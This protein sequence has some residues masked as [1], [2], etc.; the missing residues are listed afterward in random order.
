MEVLVHS[1]GLP[2][3]YI[4]VMPSR[5]ASCVLHKAFGIVVL[6]KPCL[7]ASRPDW[8]SGGAVRS[9]SRS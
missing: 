6:S 1:S 4:M 3:N 8:Q 7:Y 5:P 9:S 2:A